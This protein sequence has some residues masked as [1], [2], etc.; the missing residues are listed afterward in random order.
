MIIDGNE[1]SKKIREQLKLQISEELES[2]KRCPC[3]AVILV[4]DDPASQVYVG[5]KERA[6]LQVGITSKSFKFPADATE[7]EI[8]HLL[9]DLNKNSEIDG[10][11]VQLPLPGHISS[12]RVIDAIASSKDVD[13]LTALNQGKLALGRKSLQPCTPAGC[14]EL[15]KSQVTDLRGKVAVVV[16]RS[17]LVGSPV[18]RMLLKE[19]AT[20]IQIHSHT[21]SPEN[22]TKLADILIV[23]AGKKHLVT[24]N[25]IKPGA[26][27]IDVGIHRGEDGKLTGDV[28]FGSVSKIASAITP[29]PGG[30]GPMTIA[31]LLKNCVSAYKHDY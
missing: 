8:L 18:A 25:W 31:M 12:E 10:I 9:E 29:V 5:H 28:E 7:R 27:V 11:L 6:C 1:I 13:G 21:K 4:G 3:L 19:N 15:I 2:G 16:G 23:A 24:S 14:M 17:I 22:F 20:V 26:I 30:V